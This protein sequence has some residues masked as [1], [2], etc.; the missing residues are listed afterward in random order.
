MWILA[1]TDVSK[2]TPNGFNSISLV[3]DCISNAQMKSSTV[4]MR[5]K[6]DEVNSSFFTT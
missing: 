6:S 2:R 5:T 4:V 3:K 1:T